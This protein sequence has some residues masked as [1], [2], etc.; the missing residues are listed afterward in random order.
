MGLPTNILVPVD[1]GP[2]SLRACERAVTLARDLGARLVLLHVIDAPEYT[3]LPD[4]RGHTAVERKMGI[5]ANGLRNAGAT[6]ETRIV[7]GSPWRSVFL[8]VGT[9]H[10]ELAVSG[11][12]KRQG[13]AHIALGSV[14]GRIVRAS[15]VPVLT[16]PG[17]AFESR[18]AAG[19]KLMMDLPRHDLPG[20][21]AVV[22]LGVNA[23]PIADV[24][25]RTLGTVLDLWDCVPIELGGAVVG[26]LGEDELAHYDVAPSASET[27][28]SEA[29]KRAKEALREQL[30]YV[31]GTRSFGDVLDRLVVLVA[32]HVAS[33]AAVGAAGLRLRPPGV[34]GTL[35]VR[36]I[37]A[38]AALLELQPLVDGIVCLERTLATSPVEVAFLDDSAPS[39]RH[40]RRLLGA[41]RGPDVDP[42][43]RPRPS[44]SPRRLHQAVK[45]PST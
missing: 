2:P 1:F 37:A 35:L 22:A 26:A 25:A 20:S 15:A 32:E 10:V 39:Y 7:E 8:G 21:V 5:L 34:R 17:F 31:R 40:V 45:P 43:P 44:S 9:G 27:E 12:T 11:T 42:G 29:E 18:E 30:G 16:V 23:V 3:L 19:R 4:V 36:S 28:R 14:A 6:V 38:S 41:W 33:P 24:V 13:L